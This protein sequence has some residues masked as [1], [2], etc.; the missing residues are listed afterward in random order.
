MQQQRLSQVQLFDLNLNLVLHLYYWSRCTNDGGLSQQLLE[1]CLWK[2]QIEGTSQR[3]KIVWIL[4]ARP[5]PISWF[6]Q[7][8]LDI[9][10][11]H[12]TKCGSIIPW[13][14]RIM[15]CKIEILA[16]NMVLTSSKRGNVCNG[17]IPLDGEKY[18]TKKAM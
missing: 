12:Q 10:Q 1:K 6:C 11:K 5:G 16:R 18:V 2:Y 15:K 8:S 13:R 17:I 7:E 9:W 3:W 4:E 14:K